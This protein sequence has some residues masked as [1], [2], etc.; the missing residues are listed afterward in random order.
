MIERIMVL[1]FIKSNKIDLLKKYLNNLILND[2]NLM[3][4]KEVINSLIELGYCKQW[5]NLKSDILDITKTKKQIEIINSLQNLCNKSSV[6][7][8]E[9]Q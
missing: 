7:S 3:E 1:D 9:I 4:E 8:K 5:K 6:K 2:I